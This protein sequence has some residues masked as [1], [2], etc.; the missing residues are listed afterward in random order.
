MARGGSVV[1]FGPITP[2]VAG[3]PK[4]L[5]RLNA[6]DSRVRLRLAPGEYTFAFFIAPPWATLLPNVGDDFH[7]YASR[8]TDLGVV[9]P[10]AAWTVVGD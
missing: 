7:V 8:T 3:F 4:H 9:E 1:V 6:I 2:G 5:L 10:S